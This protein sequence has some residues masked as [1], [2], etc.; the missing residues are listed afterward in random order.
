MLINLASFLSEEYDPLADTTVEDIVHHELFHL[1][2]FQA[3]NTR[4]E[5]DPEWR[6]LNPEGFAYRDPSEGSDRPYGFTMSYGT[7]NEMEDRATVFAYLMARP[8]EL[9]A[10]GETDAV[11]RDKTRMIW[12]RLAAVEGGDAMLR[13]RATCVDWI[14]PDAP[15]ATVV[16]A[17]QPAPK[18]SDKKWLTEPSKPHVLQWLTARS[19]RPRAR[20]ATPDR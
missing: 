2:D 15:P 16:R 4:A 18:P 3:F 14:D 19:N 8:G 9:C 10:F 20:P 12:A 6:R 7:T 17:D 13:G 11:V 5:E 1:L